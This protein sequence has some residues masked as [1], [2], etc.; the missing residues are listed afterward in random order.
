MSEAEQQQMSMTDSECRNCHH[1]DPH[2]PVCRV[3]ES[4]L[5]TRVCGCDEYECNAIDDRQIARAR[6]DADH[7]GATYDP[8][9][10]RARLN[11]QQQR[12]FD[13]IK[14]AGWYTLREI[15]SALNYAYPQASISARLR[16]LRKAKFGSHRVERRR[17][18]PGTF[19]YRLIV[20]E[21]T[22]SWPDEDHRTGP[23]MKDVG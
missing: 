9:L 17:H 10:D 8:A 6:F 4:I 22:H 21:L 23:N 7:D 12:V 1:D 16:D 14:D 19:E 3:H 15:E 2:D 11:T 13:Y 20:N 5:A 18:S